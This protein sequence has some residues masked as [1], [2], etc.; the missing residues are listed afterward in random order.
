MTHGAVAAC[1]AGG[2]DVMA[3]RQHRCEVAA[4]AEQLSHMRDAS[5]WTPFK[6]RLRLT[7]GH[8]IFYLLKFSNT[9]TLIVELVTFL[10]SKFHQ[11]FHR[12]SWKHKEQ[13]SFLAQLQI[14]KGLQGIIF[15]I[16]SNWN[17]S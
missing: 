9:H 11:M 5:V 3:G 8:G 14:P 17:L 16:N 2:A 7:S 6:R 1:V 15:G 12:D 13:L 4:T 10:M